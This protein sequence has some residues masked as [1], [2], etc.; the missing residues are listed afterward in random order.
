MNAS[1]I[2]VARLRKLNTSAFVNCLKFV[3]LNKRTFQMA[4]YSHRANSSILI[5]KDLLNWN[6]N[7]IDKEY[8]LG[9]PQ[10]LPFE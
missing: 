3:S 2:Q 5:S 10:C 4:K 1:R 7:E 6:Q 8:A 9:E